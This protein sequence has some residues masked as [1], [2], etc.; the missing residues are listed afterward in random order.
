MVFCLKVRIGHIL[1]TMHNRHGD[2]CTPSH[3]E[4]SDKERKAPRC[5]T[6][7]TKYYSKW[8]SMFRIRMVSSQFRLSTWR[9]KRYWSISVHTSNLFMMLCCHSL[10][11]VRNLDMVHLFDHIAH[12]AY[13]I[14]ISGW[15]RAKAVII[16]GVAFMH[17]FD[18][19]DSKW[20]AGCVSHEFRDRESGDTGFWNFNDT[21]FVVSTMSSLAG[22]QKLMSGNRCDFRDL[23][24]KRFT[25]KA[26]S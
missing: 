10:H 6:V 3:F 26:S 9:S 23:R 7:W 18:I 13:D 15:R 14:N 16:D 1:A 19:M 8:L 4:G 5:Q 21:S 12:D 11:F 2:L 25:M 22:R 17:E 24:H 20:L